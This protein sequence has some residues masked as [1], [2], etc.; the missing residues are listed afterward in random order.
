MLSFVV[1][2]SY[3]ARKDVMEL[4]ISRKEHWKMNWPFYPQVGL[5]DADC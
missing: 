4:E 1:N 3:L 5:G 2:V